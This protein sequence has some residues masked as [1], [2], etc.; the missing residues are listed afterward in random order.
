[1]E[2][3][4]ILYTKPTITELEV[5]YATDAAANGWGNRRYDYIHRDYASAAGSVAVALYDDRLEI[6]S[7]SELHLGLTP[8]EALSGP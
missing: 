1:M 2:K 3:P 8:E 4:H 6:I 7:P 5:R